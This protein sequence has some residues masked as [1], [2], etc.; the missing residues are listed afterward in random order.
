MEVIATQRALPKKLDPVQNH[1]DFTEM[2]T[3]NKKRCT[4]LQGIRSSSNID[5]DKTTALK[6]PIAEKAAVINRYSPL[7][8]I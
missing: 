1:F 2:N 5:S 4:E 7:G 8:N 3:T 6:E